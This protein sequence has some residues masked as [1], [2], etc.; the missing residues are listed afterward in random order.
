MNVENLKAV[1]AVIRKVTKIIKVFPFLYIGIYII[2]YP[3]IAFTEIEITQDVSSWI[4]LSPLAIAFLIYLS[5]AVKLCFWHRL[6]CIL[7]LI[8]QLL[9]YCDQYIYEYGEALAILNFI[10]LL[11]L[12]TLS[13]VNA[14]FVFIRPTSKPLNHNIQ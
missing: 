8:P 10:G 11:L 14:Y 9:V 13:L 6:Q 2:I 4:Y 7:P 1:I 3:L 5:Y 12:F